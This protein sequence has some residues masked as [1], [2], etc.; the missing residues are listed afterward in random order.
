MRI[1]IAHNA[2]QQAGGEDSVVAAESAMLLSHGHPVEVYGPHND[3]IA[4]MPRLSLAGQ[5]LV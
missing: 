4:S 3:E 5:T 1:L 2:Y